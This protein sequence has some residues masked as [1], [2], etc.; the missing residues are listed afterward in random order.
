MAL[1]ERRRDGAGERHLEAVEDPGDAERHHH[2][3]V[4][5]S[6]SQAVEPR[7]NVGLDNAG[8]QWRMPDRVRRR[9]CHLRGTRHNHVA[10]PR[11]VTLLRVGIIGR[12][13]AVAQFLRAICAPGTPQSAATAAAAIIAAERTK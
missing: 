6:P 4:E 8:A 2:Q 7:R 1:L 3:G 9:G 5:A 11:Y 13:S 12:K 10:T